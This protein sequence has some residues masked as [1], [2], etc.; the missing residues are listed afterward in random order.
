MRSVLLLGSIALCLVLGSGVAAAQ[1]QRDKDWKTCES[2]EDK[3]ALD[4]CT[5]LINAGK[6]SKKDWAVVYYNRGL[7]YRR[8]GRDDDAI[9]DYSRA[10]ENDPKD[11][12]IYNNRGVAYEYKG[13][14]DRALAD[15][16]RAV[17]LNPK[18]ATAYSNRG[19]VHRK[20][21]DF[22]KAL[23]EY[24]KAVALDP[25]V[26]AY[27]AD[28][29]AVQ[30]SL[31]RYDRASQSASRAIALDAKNGHAHFV[32][33]FISYVSGDFG[34]ASSDMRRAF[35]NEGTAPA[36]I[37][38]FL[39]RAR[40]GENAASELEADAGRLKSRDWPYAVIEALLGTRP[41]DAMQAAATNDV[42]TCEANYFTA[43]WHFL[44][45]ERDSGMAALR[46]AADGCPQSE[47][48]LHGA[49]HELKRLGG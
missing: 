5:R 37:Y 16:D 8:L 9:A 18:L 14:L 24:E 43:Q 17:A 31:G 49:R 27:L 34:K 38:R 26:A 39:A 47:Y 32:R 25:K 6:H 28:L 11:A 40:V 15:Y 19:D 20:R 33:G 21:E 2:D 29:A 3:A 45:N 46:K 12:D 7:S 1:S 22:E 35:D 36:A 41:L 30:A 42:E 23:I 13:E 48:E 4:A 44:R 10:I